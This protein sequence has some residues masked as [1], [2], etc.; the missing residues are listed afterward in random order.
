M[1]I[2]Y[3]WDFPTVIG[4]NKIILPQSVQVNKGHF[5]VLKQSSSKIAINTVGNATYSDLAWN[6]T[7]QWTKLTA[8]ANWR[9]F[10]N[11]ITNFTS[12]QTTFNIQHS[13]G[14]IG[15]YNLKITFP[16]GNQIFEQIVNITD[17]KFII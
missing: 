15:L 11:A 7:T 2:I 6:F 9:F 17:C 5:I 8:F 10:L 13:Y 3:N 16:S 14:T 4:Y 1:L 12:Y